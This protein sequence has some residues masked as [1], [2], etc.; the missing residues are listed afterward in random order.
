MFPALTLRSYARQYGNCVEITHS[1]VQIVFMLHVQNPY[2]ANP[3]IPITPRL[4]R[5]LNLVHKKST[6]V[7]LSTMY[8]VRTEYGA[9]LLP[10]AVARN[11][12]DVNYRVI[13]N[14]FTF[15]RDTSAFPFCWEIECLDCYLN[16]ELSGGDWDFPI[17]AANISDNIESLLGRTRPEIK[18]LVYTSIS[19]FVNTITTVNIKEHR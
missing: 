16:S 13:K 18:A 19:E 15:Y 4:A 17:S 8:F 9:L 2:G 6:N 1:Q 10:S 11:L 7:K 3:M 12:L 5:D 14:N